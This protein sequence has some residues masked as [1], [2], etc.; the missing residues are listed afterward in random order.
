MKQGGAMGSDDAFPTPTTLKEALAQNVLLREAVSALLERVA[1]LEAKLEASEARANRNSRNSS[2]P[3]S[4]DPPEVKVGPKQQPSGRK[5]GGQPGH[6]GHQRELLAPEKVPRFEDHWPEKCEQCS[7]S[8]RGGWVTE[9]EA[10]RHQVVEVPPVCAEVVEYRLHTVVCPRC[11][12]ASTAALPSNV[13][14]SAFGPRRVAIVALM[15]GGYRLSKRTIATALW[16]LFGVQMSLGAVSA[17]EQSPSAALAQPVEQAIEHVRAQAVVHAD[18]TGW[19]QARAR[20]WL[21]VAATSLVTVFVVHRRRNGEAARTLLGAFRGILVSDRWS[22]YLQWPLHQRQLCW[23]HLKRDFHFI[24]ERGSGV[25]WIGEDLLQSSRELFALWHRVRDGTLSRAVFRR[26]VRSVRENIERLLDI[27]SR[28][29]HAKVAGMCRELLTVREALWT[30]LRVPGVEPT[31][32][33]AERSLRHPVLWRKASFGTHSA[34]GSRFVERMLTAVMSLRQQDRP[35]LDYLAA[36]NQ[37]NLE[38]IRPPSL[39]PEAA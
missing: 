10:E 3:P 9:V 8:L 25:G 33:L 39:I 16:D 22:A 27:G 12:H 28:C 13:P 36:A 21:W 4:S 19:T 30:F 1:E 18:E 38:G 31:N 34:N 17:S 35:V 26:K 2:Q 11:E 29:S 15:A 24:S 14:R 37:A 20:A 23:A 6:R 7:R 5:P 32:N